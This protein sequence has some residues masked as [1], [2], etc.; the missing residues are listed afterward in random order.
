MSRVEAASVDIDGNGVLTYTAEAGETNLLTFEQSR[1]DYIFRESAINISVESDD[2]TGDGT[3]AVTCDNSNVESIEIYLEDENDKVWIESFEHVVTLDLGSG[4]DQ[5]TWYFDNR[6]TQEDGEIMGGGGADT[7]IVE[8]DSTSDEFDVLESG[9]NLRI[10]RNVPTPKAYLDISD[11]AYLDI[12]LEG[13]DDTL[14]VLGN[15]DDVEDIS[16]MEITI[17]GGE[18]N[19][20][21]DASDIDD[22]I[23]DD[24]N[25][26]IFG[27]EGDDLLNGSK[28][29][30]S[31]DCG[32]GDD[33]YEDNGGFD[34]IDDTCNET[35]VV[36]TEPFSDIDGN[37]FKSY[38][39]SLY[40]NG[41]VSGSQGRFFPNEYLTRGQYAKVIF[42]GLEL[43]VNV[44]C[45]GFPDVNGTD[46]FY[47]YITSLK[48]HGIVSGKSN[49]TY[50]SEEPISR[51][52]AA[53]I[54]VEALKYKNANI[55]FTD[56][57]IQFND[58]N[59]SN[60][61][62]GYIILIASARVNGEAIM[63]GSNGNFMPSSFMTRGEMAKVVSNT[64]SYWQASV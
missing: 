47:N 18:G 56:G 51:G 1:D 55:F 32:E 59:T 24:M 2:C 60:P 45:G 30:D 27:D 22:G 5:A 36:A 19:D 33:Q 15:L 43:P 3:K 10:K 61:F 25:L 52:A 42:L 58:L 34:E 13:G 12:K 7:L 62:Y 37:I 16:S 38:I 23:L 4:S 48:C 64:R 49:G 26:L 14:S 53:K 50:G 46:V 44:G 63:G 8:G 57:S 21:I 20:E 11:F 35:V 54:A 31:I 40:A 39:E 6:F 28:G 41:I 29:K 9:G 17:E